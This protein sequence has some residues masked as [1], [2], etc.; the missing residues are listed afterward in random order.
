MDPTFGQMLAD[1]THIKLLNGGIDKWSQLL[2][3]IGQLRIE[4]LGVE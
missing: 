4:V 1:A 3:F 2:P